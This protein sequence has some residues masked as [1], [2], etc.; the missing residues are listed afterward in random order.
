M[1]KSICINRI[2]IRPYQRKGS[3]TLRWLADI[4]QDMA[5]GKRCR[6]FFDSVKE[7]KDFANSYS[8]RL[9]RGLNPVNDNGTP[10][11]TFDELTNNWLENQILRVSI[12]KKK[13]SSLETDRNRLKKVLPRIGGQYLDGFDTELLE[14]YQVQRLG[15]NVSPDTVNSD[16]KLIRKVMNWGKQRKIDCAMPPIEPLQPEKREMYIPTPKEMERVLAN[17]CKKTRLVAR[18]ILETGCRAGEAY[19]LKWDHL[20][21]SNL[22]ASIR[23]GESWTPKTKHSARTIPI[24]HQLADDLSRLP[25]V[26]AYVF[27]GRVPKK[28]LTSIRKGLAAG[29]R[30]AGLIHK[31]QPVHLCVHDLRKINASWRAMSGVPERVLQDLLGHAPGTS[32]TNKHYVFTNEDAKRK[33]VFSIN[34]CANDA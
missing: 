14:W 30:K 28:P 2:R 32:V 6:K 17:V 23:A 15:D 16:I 8:S 20:D 27:P 3:S 18:F 19:N 7:A 21:L 24:S 25:K 10:R 34:A 26:S 4:P 11:M 1:S 13:P 12:G 33:A 9:F 5:G 22:E 29:V 31:G